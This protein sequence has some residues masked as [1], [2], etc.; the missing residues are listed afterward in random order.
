MNIAIWS[1]EEA[2]QMAEKLT[3]CRF[4]TFQEVLSVNITKAVTESMQLYSFE[5][6]SIVNLIPLNDF[7]KYLK[8]LSL[9]KF[10]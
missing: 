8:S 4:T 7:A 1:G 9:V 3:E 10:H 5:Y 6:N 2:E